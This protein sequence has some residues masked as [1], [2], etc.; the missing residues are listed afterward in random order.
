MIANGY[1]EEQL[2]RTNQLENIT[3]F[4]VINI[5]IVHYHCH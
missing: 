5:M 3:K 1:Q 2:Y 4:I